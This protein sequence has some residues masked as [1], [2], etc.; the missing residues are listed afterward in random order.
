MLAIYDRTIPGNLRPTRWFG[1]SRSYHGDHRL[2]SN[3]ALGPETPDKSRNRQKA[4]RESLNA[5]GLQRI[6]DHYFSL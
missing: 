4:R 5:G 2:K 3:C 1:E 6:T